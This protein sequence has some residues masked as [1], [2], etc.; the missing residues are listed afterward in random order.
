MLKYNL[1]R[2]EYDMKKKKMIW[3]LF[4]LGISFILNANRVSAE[5]VLTVSAPVTMKAV[6]TGYN[7]TKLSWSTVTDAAGYQIYRAEST[8]GTY[9]SIRATK[10]TYFA[11][12]NLATGK[13]YYYKVKAYKYSGTAK[14]FSKYS[15]AVGVKPVPSTPASFNGVSAAVDQARLT[16]KSVS[17]AS[18]YQVYRATSGSG[19]YNLIKTTPYLSYNNI[20]LTTGNTYYYK[21][22]AYKTVGSAKVYGSFTAM[23]SVKPQP[24]VPVQF[25]ITTAGDTGIKV[26]WGAV[27]GASGYQVSRATSSAGPFSSVKVTTSTSFTNT[28]LSSGTAY[29]YKVRAYRMVG[30]NKVYGEFT[31]VGKAVTSGFNESVAVNNIASQFEDTGNGVIAI[32]TNNNTYSVSLSATMV[33]YDANGTMIGKST[34][35]NYFFEPGKKSALYFYGPY[36]GDFNFINYSSYK[37]VY[38]ID[39][40]SFQ[41]SN[42]SDIKTTSNI[43]SDNVM[44]EV[45]NSGNKS[46]EF[47]KIGIVFY[48]DGKAVAYD[49]GY[50]DCE[51]PGSSDYLE[52]SFPYDENINTIQ[53]DNYEIYINSSYSYNY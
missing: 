21:V 20:N 16:W 12:T 7:S 15:S 49:Y 3:A 45:T 32:L 5:I 10:Y 28:G 50:A 47:T 4:I 36:D 9:K 22:R 35:D 31:T 18:G 40:T 23:T 53:I 29:Y 38:S 13:T 46:A 30:S 41:I 34:D 19:T 39:D 24:T 11:D 14:V 43:G 37:I 44:V 1:H 6:S 51:T 33:F 48:K 27:S 42:L 8:T 2:R 26:S 25:S 52:F 17:G